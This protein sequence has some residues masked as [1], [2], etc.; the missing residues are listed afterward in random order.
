MEMVIKQ[1]AVHWINL[2]PTIGSEIN[3][4]RPCVIIS[5]D[6]MNQYIKTVIVAPLTHTIKS[7]PTRVICDI[8][9]DKG[10]IVLDQ[11]RTVDKLRIGKFLTSLNQAEIAEIKSVLNQMLC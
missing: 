2:D 11:I 3:K 9:G 1:Y 5:P 10:S 4:T 7:Y 8:K 6:E